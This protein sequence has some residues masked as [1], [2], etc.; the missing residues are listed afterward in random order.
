MD[1]NGRW[2]ADRGKPRPFGHREGSKA[3][4]RIVRVSR[5]IGLDALTLYAFSFQNWARPDDEVQALMALLQ[6]YLVSERDEIL[7]RGIRLAAVGRLERLPG[8]VRALLDSLCQESAANDGMTLTL[9][10]SYGG[11]E[12]IVEVARAL[13]AE[14][15]T[16]ELDPQDID[17]ELI[18]KRIP[19]QRVG[20]PDLIIR[21]GGEKRLSNFLLYGSAYAELHFSDRLWPDFAEADLFEA[22]SSFQQRERRFGQVGKRGPAKPEATG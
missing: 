22:I 16:G 1:G 9:A 15:A 5:R 13:A 12:E 19:S 11:R 2:A 7:E 21:T 17:A 3:V 20:E 10:L 18:G 6:E 14:V 8:P 4:R